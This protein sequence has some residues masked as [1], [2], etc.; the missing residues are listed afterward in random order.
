MSNLSQRILVAVVGI[1]IVV[2][3]IF[4][5][6]SLLGL[7]IIFALLAVHEFYN[8]AK[9]KGFIPQVGIGMA[10]TALI[11]LTFGGMHLHDLL[12]TLHIHVGADVETTALVPVLLILGT[13]VTLMAELFKGYPNPLVQVSV[14][15]GGAL[16]IGLGLGGFYGVHEYFYIHAAMTR[17]DIS[18]AQVSAQAGYF[19]I[20]LL[21]SIWICDSA[22]YF[23]GRSFGRHK[24]AVRVSPNKSWEGGI[25][26]LIAA[27]A[28]W[29]IA[30]NVLDSL[31]EVS[32]TTAIAMGL[33][34]GVLGQIGDFAESMF[35]RDVGVKD[36]SALI[37]GHGGVLDRLDSILFIFPTTYVYLHLFGI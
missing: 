32:L 35:K 1:P 11:V 5:P 18:P 20:L 28:T 27:I 21:A 9:A 19:T 17:L 7:A 33:I 37:P 13:I 10:L 25:A 12:A 22:A 34:T 2:L 24:I 16:Y 26:G 30:I 4:K 29:I 8:L 23:I 15:L 6:Y 3:V 36:S 14:T 31:A